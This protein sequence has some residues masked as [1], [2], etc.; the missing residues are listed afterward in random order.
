ML[1]TPTAPVEGK[2]TKQNAPTIY[3]HIYY[4]VVIY[5]PGPPVQIYFVHAQALYKTIENNWEACANK[6]TLWSRGRETCASWN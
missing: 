1:S 2:K 3:T 6:A 5:N 4:M